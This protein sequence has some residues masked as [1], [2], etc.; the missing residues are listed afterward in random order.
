[1]E[2]TKKIEQTELDATLKNGES[3]IT[4]ARQ[5][6]FGKFEPIENM[7][8][9]DLKREV[10]TWRALWSWVPS[11]IKYYISRTGALV[12]VTVRNYKRYV[13]VLLETHWN[14]EEIEIGTYDRVY[15][16]TSG[17]YY[18]ERKIVKLP[19]TQIIALDWIAER[20]PEKQLQQEQEQEE[21]QPII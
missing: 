18:Y 10:Q 1:M 4:V 12:G 17:E 6:L 7:S 13:G 21:P 14:L 9:D 2:N 19:A 16:Q 20:I 15:D 11:E 8:I 3:S 5:L